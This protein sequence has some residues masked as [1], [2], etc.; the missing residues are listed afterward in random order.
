[1]PR[2][3][4]T[5]AYDGTDFCGWQ[6]QEPPAEPAPGAPVPGPAKVVGAIESDRP[7]RI[8]LRSVQAV[9][10]DAVR[11]VIR[12]PILL[13]GASRTD[14]GVHARAQV[15]A[16][17]SDPVPDRGV[18]W[19]PERGT[20]PL[21]RAINSRLP[22]DAL[23]TRA[24]LVPH[25]FDPISDC[26]GK[27][28]SYSIIASPDRPIF[29]RRYAAHVRH[30]L[31]VEAMNAAA[32]KIVGEHD[33]A[34]FAAAGHGRQSTVRR[35]FN[36]T[37]SRPS[38]R[39]PGPHGADVSLVSPASPPVSGHSR[40]PAL[41]HLRID[42]SGDGFLY[43]MVRIIAGTLVKVGRGRIDSSTIPDILGSKDRRQA[44]PTMPP[45]GLC[46]EW[47]RYKPRGEREPA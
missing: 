32:A 27:G 47:I 7:G 9:V 38:D 36:C 8:V 21:R 14:A 16:F 43:N 24:D 20:E 37:V 12:E 4:L 33:F 42:I 3:A 34:A 26:T 5:I 44:G 30:A 19:P 45:Q 10:E 31:D 25:D 1:M 22:E 6:K 41:E 46:L 18:G 28:Y 17:T 23:L 2:Y 39:A 35:V 40:A 13:K 15:A 29:E 11:Q